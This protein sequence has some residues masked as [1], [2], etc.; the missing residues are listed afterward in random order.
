MRFARHIRFRKVALT[1]CLALILAFTVIPFARSE[2]PGETDAQEFSKLDENEDGRLSGSEAAAFK[3]YD[4]NADGK[5][6]LKE[7]LAGRQKERAGKG[8][9]QPATATDKTDKEINPKV[10]EYNRKLKAQYEGG[11]RWAIIIGVSKY[12]V[13]PIAGAAGGAR[14][15]AEALEKYCGYDPSRMVLMV[16][17]ARDSPLHPTKKNIIAQVT[18]LLKE[19]QEKDTLLVTFSGHGVTDKGISYL[20][21]IEFDSESPET[22]WKADELR[23][24]LH[25]CRASQKLLVL[26]SCH[27]GG[28]S[29]TPELKPPSSQEMGTAFEQSRGLITFASC[30][31]DETALGT[32]QYGMFTYYLVRGLRG[33]ADF[34]RNGIVDSDELYKYVLLEV[35]IA[36]AEAKAHRKQTPVRIMGEDVVGVFALSRPTGKLEEEKRPARIKPGEMFENSIGMK[37]ISL[38]PG[39]F[40]MGS[41]E[42]EYRRSR[43]EPVEQSVTIASVLLMGTHEVT[44]D[45]YTSVMGKNPSYFSANGGGS[46]LVEG[47]KTKNFP[48]EQVSWIDAMKFCETLSNLP[49]ERAAFRMYRLPTEAEW[50]FACRAKTITVFHCGDTLSSEQANI[51]GDKPYL[52][53]PEGPTLGRTAKVGSYKPN[54]FGLYDMH[55]NVAEWCLDW[56]APRVFAPLGYVSP[57]LI[58]QLDT[59]GRKEMAS[60]VNPEGPK[61]GETRVFRGGAYTGD[62]TYARSAARR[63][64]DPGLRSRSIG[65]RVVCQIVRPNP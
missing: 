6:T 34:D 15:L 28:A 26:D 56:Y 54:A 13:S 21:P 16:D 8:Q 33:A 31:K 41:P 11:N 48:V 35:P 29:A 20:C 44:Q 43:D 62:V 19:I 36:V 2:N 37:L 3:G 9:N 52:D 55:G 38:P 65:F 1:A 59:K 45:Q 23:A 53:S 10:E 12:K 46:E 61:K 22:A 51:R 32:Q 7:F 40:L 64:N 58:K 17:G 24:I 27:S 60:P 30:R 18:T 47:L 5:V 39:Q 4:A 25:E 42:N 57:D 63:H 14:M 50:E 49:E